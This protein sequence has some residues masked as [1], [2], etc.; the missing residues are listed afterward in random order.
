MKYGCFFT[1]LL[2]CAFSGAGVGQANV[3]AKALSPLEQTLMSAE[4]G[5]VDAAKKGDVEMCI[6]DSPSALAAGW[7]C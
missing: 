4:K 5:F 7:Q 2:G 3:P 1:I 6:R